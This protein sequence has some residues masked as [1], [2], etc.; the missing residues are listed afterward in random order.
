MPNRDQRR[1][2]GTFEYAQ[3]DLPKR[4]REEPDGQEWGHQHGE[5]IVCPIAVCWAADGE[6]GL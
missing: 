5:G 4:R 3:L 1:R 6:A 2:D